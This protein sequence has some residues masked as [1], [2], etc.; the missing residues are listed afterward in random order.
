MTDGESEEDTRR[1]KDRSEQLKN[2]FS[3]GSDTTQSTDQDPTE[4]SQTGQ[5]TVKSRKHATFYLDE[6]LLT[7]L[8]RAGQQAS[9]RYEDAYGSTL[10]K[11]RHL[12]PLVIRLGLQE[13]QEL[14]AEA[15]REALEEFGDDS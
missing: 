3:A 14:D 9:W 8:E 6:E 1:V 13:L 10:E 11:N 15:I 5:T 2:R 12:R 7:E 4:T